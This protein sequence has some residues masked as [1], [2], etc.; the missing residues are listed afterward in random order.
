MR[1]SLLTSDP[2]SEQL[3]I[4]D[5]SGGEIN[6]KGFACATVVP[7][8]GPTAAGRLQQGGSGVAVAPLWPEAI[9]GGSAT[10]ETQPRAALFT[11]SNTFQS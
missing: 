4:I 2:G 3:S 1:G 11:Y 8:R 7:V 5:Q 10:L 6:E 9:R